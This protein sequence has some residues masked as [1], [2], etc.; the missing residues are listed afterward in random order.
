MM[1]ELNWAYEVL[2]GYIK[3]YRFS[4]SEEEIVKQ[5]PG[6]FIKKFRI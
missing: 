5:Y 4:F 1:R 3:E 6:E 2:R